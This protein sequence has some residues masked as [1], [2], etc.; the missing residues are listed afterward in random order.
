MQLVSEFSYLR[1]LWE[2]SCRS[3]VTCWAG[4]LEGRDLVRGLNEGLAELIRRGPGTQWIGDTSDIGV[5]SKAD[6]Q[7]VDQDWFPR[8]V[9]SGAQF[10]AV[11]HP[12]SVIAKLVVQEIVA[13][14]AEQDLTVYNCATMDEAVAWMRRQEF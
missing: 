11:V 9:A 2:E 7:W 8:L 14:F 3:V 4:G 1:I 10:M 13:K 12:R 6:R 5:I